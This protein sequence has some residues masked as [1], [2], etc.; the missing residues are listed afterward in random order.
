MP[1]RAMRSCASRRQ[2]HLAVN[3][4]AGRLDSARYCK[5]NDQCATPEEGALDL[6]KPGGDVSAE[7]G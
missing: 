5:E 7:R 2:I 6:L 4:R 1:E 3:V